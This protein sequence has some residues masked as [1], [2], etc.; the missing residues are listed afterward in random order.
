MDADAE[1]VHGFKI[2]LAVGKILRQEE[3][4]IQDHACSKPQLF[5]CAMTALFTIAHHEGVDIPTL[6]S[7]LMNDWPEVLDSLKQ[8]FIDM[9]AGL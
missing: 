7:D 8:M 2:G 1:M 5:V 9:R 3:A 4:A 6:L